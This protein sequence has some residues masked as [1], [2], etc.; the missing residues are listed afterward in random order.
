MLY[1]KSNSMNY[2]KRAS[3]NEKMSTDYFYFNSY[4]MGPV[5]RW[6]MPIFIYLDLKLTEDKRHIEL[7]SLLLHVI[8]DYITF[9][10]ILQTTTVFLMK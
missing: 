5:M 10:F 6:I 9:W 4:L 3:V 7:M 2:N 8:L 1:V